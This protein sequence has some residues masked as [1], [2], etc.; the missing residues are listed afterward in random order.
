MCLLQKWEGSAEA[1]LRIQR[2]RFTTFV[3]VVRAI[4][5]SKARHSQQPKS[6][7]VDASYWRSYGLEEELIRTF[8]HVFLL[9]SAFVIF[10]NSV[11]R[12]VL[13]EMTIDLTCAEDIFQARSPEEFSSALKLHEP[14]GD[15]PLL[16]ECVRNLCAERPNPAVIATLYKES[17]MNLFTIATATGI[18]SPPTGNGP[19]QNGT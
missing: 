8:N 10:H 6:F 18:R 19:A 5:L 13:Q 2:Q 17:P 9:D 12:M 7:A 11:P 4:G 16:T 3:A 1:K 15:R 14:H